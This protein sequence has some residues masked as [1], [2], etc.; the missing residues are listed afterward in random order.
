MPLRWPASRMPDPDGGD[1]T[2]QQEI[3]G[4]KLEVKALKETLGTLISWMVTS[5]VSP[6]RMDEASTLLNILN[7]HETPTKK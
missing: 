6:I 7:G 4:L 2:P 5:S 3:A 1:V